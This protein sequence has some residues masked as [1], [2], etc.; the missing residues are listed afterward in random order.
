[1]QRSG[2]AHHLLSRWGLSFILILGLLWVASP[3]L[4]GQGQRAQR[5]QGL[6]LQLLC[7]GHLQAVNLALSQY[8]LD[9][10]GRFPPFNSPQKLR[11]ILAEYKM[12]GGNLVC[13]ISNQDYR[14]NQRLSGK[15]RED[16]PNA[17]KTLLMWSSKPL[18]DGNY[19]VLTVS[20]LI[21][22]VS[23]GELAHY[24]K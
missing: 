19:M 16:V 3:L 10:D 7:R 8:V 9:N 15:K 18:A 21:Q 1:M 17:S 2:Y 13:P 24:K 6:R 4:Q 23:A 5:I 14:I 11:K 20:G 12:M 22:R